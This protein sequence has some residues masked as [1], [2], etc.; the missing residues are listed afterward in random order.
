MK[1]N[2]SKKDIY[3]TYFSKSFTLLSGIITLPLILRWLTDEEI[4]VNY[5]FLNIISYT[6]IFDL[7]FSPQFSRNVGFA[8]GGAPDIKSEGYILADHGNPNYRLVKNII[9]SAQYLYGRIALVVF[10]VLA[11]FGTIY[12]Q[13]MTSNYALGGEIVWM[14]VTFSLLETFDFY[15]K[16]YTP[17]LQGKGNIAELNEIDFVSSIIKVILTVIFLF[18]GLR[19]WA[20]IIGVFSKIL[21]TR[22]MSVYVFYYKDGLKEKLNEFVITVSEKK[23]IIRRIWHNARRSAIVQ[24]ASFCTTQMGFLFTGI[25]LSAGEISS[26]G[27][28]MQLTMII[29]GVAMSLSQSV[30]P[31]YAQ[32]RTN[33]DIEGVKNNFYFTTGMYYIIFIAGSLFLVF[34]CP[35]LLNIIR[36]NAVL[37]SLPVI[38]IYLLY[39][40]LEGQHCI[41]IF[42]ISSK[43]K[44]YDTESAVIMAISTIMLLYIFLK[45]LNAGLLAVVFVQLIVAL[46]YSNW[47]WPY[48]LCKDFHIT[49]FEMVGYSIKRVGLRLF[50]R[51]KR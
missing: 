4:A 42:C 40:F 18:I 12:V 2:L 10:I 26:Y 41:C 27:L 38:F 32:L 15:Y 48:E 6:I 43:N 21:I 3:W 5:L 47:K 29:T 24:I 34:V 49:Y 8:F 50:K 20:V 22:L 16:F 51:I 11:L 25:Y 39:K 45:F 37:P 30:S 9:S 28:L 23:D 35:G 44:I 19:L 13:E 46:V 14:W 31:I 1:T 17:L 36:S 7:G 33:N